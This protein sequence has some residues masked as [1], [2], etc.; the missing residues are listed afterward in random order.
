MKPGSRVTAGSL[1]TNAQKKAKSQAKNQ[2]TVLLKLK[3][4][5]NHMLVAFQGLFSPA[6]GIQ[7]ELFPEGC[8]FP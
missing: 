1:G 6:W 4:T 5:L 3:V 2:W 7:G 8:R